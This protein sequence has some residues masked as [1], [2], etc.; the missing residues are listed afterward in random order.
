MSSASARVPSYPSEFIASRF[1]DERVALRGL[2]E[3]WVAFFNFWK[4][5]I[6]TEYSR[7]V[8]RGRISMRVPILLILGLLVIYAVDGNIIPN[9]GKGFDYKESDKCL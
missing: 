9:E 3:I 5:T 7:K 6:D 8:Y 2:Q 4:S 1:Q